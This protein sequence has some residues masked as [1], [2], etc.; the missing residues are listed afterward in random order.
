METSTTETRNE[1]RIEVEP[2]AFDPCGDL[3]VTST[4]NLIDDINKILASSFNDYYGC[5]IS[6]QYQP[7]RMSFAIIPT[8]VF[9][10]LP[11]A[12]YK[13][14]GIFAFIPSSATDAGDVL[15]RVQ[16]ITRSAT[17]GKLVTMTQDGKD[18]LKH[19]MF[20]QFID[21][22]NVNWEE[23]YRTLTTAGNSF[24]VV[25]KF[26]IYKF[27]TAIYGS[28]DPIDAKEDDPDA[29]VFYQITPSRII[30][31]QYQYKTADEW[32]V[33]IQRIHA[34][35]MRQAAEDLHMFMPEQ[36]TGLQGIFPASGR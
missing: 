26:D 25:N 3:K 32:S 2:K 30:N 10:V 1:Y 31:S 35:N 29:K 13:K 36:F 14:D 18:A 22:K 34:G 24:V 11:D 16:R 20:D 5:G 12:D 9:K 28:T 21:R 7:D 27:L 19:F 8:V 23:S 33:I 4:K 15:G 6:V 17:L